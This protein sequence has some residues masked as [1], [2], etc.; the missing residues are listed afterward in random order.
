[1]AFNIAFLEVRTQIE[2]DSNGL[3]GKVQL[4][5]D[6]GR[7][8]SKLNFSIV[9]MGTLR[10]FCASVTAVRLTA[11]VHVR[12]KEISAKKSFVVSII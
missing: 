11:C 5:F 7:V 3:L 4:K 8:T 2:I 1:M 12:P 10:V 6:G 9:S